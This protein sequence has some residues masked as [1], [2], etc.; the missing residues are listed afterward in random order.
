MGDEAFPGPVPSGRT[1]RI[2]PGPDL[3]VQGSVELA[4]PVQRLWETFLDVPSWPRWNHCIWRSSVRGGRLRTGATLVWAFNPIDR[5]YLYK[6][7]RAP[8][9][10]S[11]RPPTGSPGK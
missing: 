6:L 10:W 7:R 9:S 5:R 2:E 8:R 3:P 1:G 4:M 11:W